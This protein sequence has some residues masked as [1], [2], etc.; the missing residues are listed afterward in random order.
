MHSTCTLLC[1]R[2]MLPFIFA[3]TV[4]G[5]KTVYVQCT[6]P[7]VV[8]ASLWTYEGQYSHSMVR[9]MQTTGGQDHFRGIP[10]RIIF[11]N[12]PFV[13]TKTALPQCVEHSI[14]NASNH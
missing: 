6:K 14:N 9:G 2:L 1:A 3:C 5:T 11:L 7:L 12:L 10:Q 13:A 4:F 8:A